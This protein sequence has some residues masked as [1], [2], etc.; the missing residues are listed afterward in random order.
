[1]KIKTINSVI[2]GARVRSGPL[3]KILLDADSVCFYEKEAMVKL[4]TL[5]KIQ[6]HGNPIPDYRGQIQSIISLLGMAVEA[7]ERTH[8]PSSAETVR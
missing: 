3:T 1:M 8:G 5:I 4:S 7:E 2:S 6:D